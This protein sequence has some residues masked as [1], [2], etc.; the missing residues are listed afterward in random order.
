VRN[1]KH[2]ATVIAAVALFIAF[3]GGAAAYASGLINGSK[4][5]NHSIATKKLTKKAIKQLH[6]AKGATGPAGPAGAPGA[7]GPQGPGG[8][9]VTWDATASA[10]PTYKT[11]GTFLGDTFQAA[12]ATSSGDSELLIKF[13][14]SDGSW[15]SEI[16]IS[17]SAGGTEFFNLVA[18]AGTYTSSTPLAGSLES[19]ASG[20]NTDA[21]HWANLKL[22]PL[23]AGE[24]IWNATTSTVSGSTCHL[25]IETIPEALTK[26]TAPHAA[27]TAGMHLPLHFGNTRLH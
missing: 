9:I 11:I 5:K 8:T 6:G 7:T 12:C 16:D 3:G 25:S 20:G 18:P 19:S 1:L 2:P 10:S 23:P 22:G 26:V 27:P 15:N 14:T 4:I 17:D 21:V 24:E 13:Y